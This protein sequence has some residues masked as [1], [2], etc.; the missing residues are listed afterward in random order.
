MTKIENH[1]APRKRVRARGIELDAQNGA[2]VAYE[3]A[4]LARRESNIVA[5][6]VV[7]GGT[8]IS[9]AFAA[10]DADANGHLLFFPLRLWLSTFTFFS[11]TL[12]CSLDDEQQQHATLSPTHERFFSFFFC[13]ASSC[14]LFL[15]QAR[16][17]G[18][19][20]GLSFFFLAG[21]TRREERE[22]E[23][24]QKEHSTKKRHFLVS[25]D[26]AAT[27][28]TNERTFIIVA[29]RSWTRRAFSLELDGR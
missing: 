21:R 6:V 24:R 12:A 20:L 26:I 10:I 22:R 5:V 19:P 1:L 3:V 13:R 14:L 2:L 23:G 18:R 7:G 8:I 29:S 25:F 17:L 4:S 16:A 27:D 11:S 15:S 28:I 9:A